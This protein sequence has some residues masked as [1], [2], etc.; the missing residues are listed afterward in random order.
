LS[1]TKETTE[2]PVKDFSPD[3]K[4]YSIVRVGNK[5]YQLVSIDFDSKS[6]SVASTTVVKEYDS[7]ARA[8]KELQTGLAEAARK[9][10]K[11]EF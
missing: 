2:N 4:A 7:E 3:Y 11:Q 10:R 5:K 1:Y 9:F 8:L 6:G